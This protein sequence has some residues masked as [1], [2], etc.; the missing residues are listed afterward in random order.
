MTEADY[1]S[2]VAQNIKRSHPIIALIKPTTSSTFGYDSNG[3][4]VVIKGT[5]HDSSLNYYAVVNDP[6]N[7]YCKTLR[8][9]M[10]EMRTLL[11][12]HASGGYI[13]YALDR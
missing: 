10:S 12:N 3:H 4:Y 6:H 11:L 1:T 8:L 2:L 13:I 9:K 5:N 7:N